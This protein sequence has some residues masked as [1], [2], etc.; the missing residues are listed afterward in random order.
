MLD[1]QQTYKHMTEPET[2][3]PPAPNRPNCLRLAGRMV[4]SL[5]FVLCL[6]AVGGVAALFAPGP[7][8]QEKNIVI[9]HGTKTADMGAQLAQEKAVYAAPLFL[10]ATRLVAS[11]SLKAG[12][13]ALPA[14]ASPVDIALMMHEGHSV[15]RLFTAAEGLTS[16]EIV[17]MLNA[18]SVLTGTID[19]SPAEG[20]LLPETY[21]YTY[22]DSRA[23]L[24]ARMQKSMQERQNDLWGK[25]DK[26]LPL[27]SLKE[28]VTLA[29]IVE[30]ETGTP[31][32]RPRIAGVFFNRL[33]LNMR[34]QSDP[35]VIY[36]ITKGKE[37]LDRP[38]THEDLAFASPINTYASDGIPPQPICNPGSASLEA[39]LHPEHNGYLYFVA[40]GTGGHAFAA[41]LAAHNKNISK[42]RQAIE[43]ASSHK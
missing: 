27:Q 26:D 30:K 39:V 1:E 3:P 20:S 29:S 8:A 6:T 16:A 41:D 43:N 10:A 18:D 22:G 4:A 23:S 7:L 42:W 5:G 38:L 15:V 9:A 24:I 40:T 35:T 19:H 21:R 28:A 33:R 13:Y 17:R 2:P 36:A 25:R 37:F 14:H 31:E 34:L 11:N 12:E 32:E